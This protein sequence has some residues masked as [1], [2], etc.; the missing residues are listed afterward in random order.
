MKRAIESMDIQPDLALID[1]NQLPDLQIAAKAIVKGDLYI[2]AISA[3]SILAKVTRD[4]IMFDLVQE[5]PEYGFDKHVGYGTKQHIEAI[6]RHG[7]LPIHRAGFAPV[8][9]LL[10]NLN[11]D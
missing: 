4:R 1:G 8:K 10:I 9:N 2:P 7:V 3:A 6:H 11:M 5:Y